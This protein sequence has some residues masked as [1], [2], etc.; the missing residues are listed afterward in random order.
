[1][2]F[3]FCVYF[4]LLHLIMDTQLHSVCLVI[5]PLIYV[6][7]TWD[8]TKQDIASASFHINWPIPNSTTGHHLD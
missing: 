3:V 5:H 8:M 7:Q 4:I 6:S 2:H 1:M